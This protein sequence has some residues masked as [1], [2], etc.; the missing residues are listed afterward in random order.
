MRH[1][2]TPTNFLQD[3]S[4]EAT[5][6]EVRSRVD[7]LKRLPHG[8]NVFIPSLERDSDEDRIAAAATI[9][10]LGLNPVPHIAARRVRSAAGLQSVLSRLQSDARTES[11]LIVAGDCEPVGPY[12]SALS[13]IETG[14]LPTF[15]IRRV[16]ISGYPEGH[17][18]IDT[19]TLARHMR[20]KIDALSQQ[21][22]DVELITQFSFDADPVLAWLE[23]LRGEVAAPVRLGIP[24]PANAKT[25]LKFATMC[26][27][28]ASAK[29][30]AKYGLTLTKLLSSA[31]PDALVDD[32]A[33]RLDPHLHGKVLAHFYPFGGLDRTTSW[34]ED[35]TARQSLRVAS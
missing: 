25:L 3:Y 17:P 26:G 33:A 5:T 8:T 31:G 24:G 12:P 2:V 1:F 20:A 35:Y 4:T 29:V 21:N 27:V 9:R 10:A 19:A 22:V 28:G 15:G 16:A 6:A 30:L 11:L 13:I 23:H 32:L 34:I 7:Q 18:K 14:L